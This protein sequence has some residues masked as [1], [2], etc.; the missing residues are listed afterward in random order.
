LQAS[1]RKECV[2]DGVRLNRLN[3]LKE[4]KFF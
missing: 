2:T 4:I 1:A 3:T